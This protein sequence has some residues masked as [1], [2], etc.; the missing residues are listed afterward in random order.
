LIKLIW[1]N[2]HK[3]LKKLLFPSVIILPLI[4]AV[5]SQY[6]SEGKLKYSDTALINFLLL[7][8]AYLVVVIILALIISYSKI[9]YQMHQ[10]LSQIDVKPSISSSEKSIKINKKSL[11]MSFELGVINNNNIEYTVFIYR[12]WLPTEETPGIE[13]FIRAIHFSDGRCGKCQSDFYVDSNNWYLCTNSKCEND[14]RISERDL[15]TIKEKAIAE[16]SGTV[17][18]DYKKYWDAYKKIYDR[19]TNKNYD[20]YAK[21]I[22]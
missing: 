3:N 7:F 2:I 4:V 1:Q 8:S 11:P 22:Y 12:K 5:L 6:I 21:P 15:Y 20:E 19:Y 17:R 13:D 10:K 14:I 18:N 16:Y 9:I